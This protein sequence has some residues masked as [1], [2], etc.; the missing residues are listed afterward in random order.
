MSKM[1]EE[2]MVGQEAY[3]ELFMSELRGIAPSHTLQ[4]KAVNIGSD[5]FAVLRTHGFMRPMMFAGDLNTVFP[6]Q[7]VSISRV[8]FWGAL[9]LADYG[10]A[11]FGMLFRALFSLKGVQPSPETC[12]WLLQRR[13]KWPRF[14]P[15]LV[16]QFLQCARSHDSTLDLDG[17]VWLLTD[18]ES[19]E[20][21]PNGVKL[22]EPNISHVRGKG[23]DRTTLES[24]YRM[25]GCKNA[26]LTAT[27]TF[28]SCVAALAGAQTQY[29][30]Y[31]D[32]ICRQHSFVDPVDRGTL[33]FESKEV[34]MLLDEWA[35]YSS[36]KKHNIL[37]S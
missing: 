26:V 8:D 19:Q 18:A 36:E 17:N 7:V 1:N 11:N 25:S 10:Q 12:S 2:E 31:E 15:P 22:V 20:D 34:T 5:S 3:D 24:M 6:Y 27:S 23:G 16:G 14:A 30:I 35:A 21:I 29:E 9:L 13:T 37:S 4:R 33:P 32:G 28:G